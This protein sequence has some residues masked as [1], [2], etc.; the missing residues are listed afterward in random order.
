MSALAPT[1][2]LDDG[3]DGDLG[4]VNDQL[5]TANSRLRRYGCARCLFWTGKFALSAG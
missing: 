5:P 1:P 3:A 2:D 4:D